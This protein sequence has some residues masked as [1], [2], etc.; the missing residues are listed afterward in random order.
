MGLM[1]VKKCSKF[2]RFRGRMIDEIFFFV[3][4]EFLKFCEADIGKKQTLKGT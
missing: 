4:S 3:L 2:H 1:D